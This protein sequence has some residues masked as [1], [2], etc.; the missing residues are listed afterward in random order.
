MKN[1]CPT[2][3]THPRK[4][5]GEEK[6]KFIKGKQRIQKSCWAD[7]TSDSSKMKARGGNKLMLNS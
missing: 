6:S 2:L 5:K 3:K 7:S 1:D 4:E